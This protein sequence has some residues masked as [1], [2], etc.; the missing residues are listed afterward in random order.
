MTWSLR[1]VIEERADVVSIWREVRGNACVS[2][3]TD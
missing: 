2:V 3:E 1:A